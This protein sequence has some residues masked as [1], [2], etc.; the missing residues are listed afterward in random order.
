MELEE[1]I[2]RMMAFSRATYG[3]GRKTE[4]LI[5]HIR[6][7]LEEVVNA[8]TNEERI[9]EWVDLVILSLDG[10]WREIYEHQKQRYAGHHQ[11]VD[12]ENSAWNETPD[13]LVHYLTQKQT[14]NEL[15]DWPDWRTAPEGEPIEHVKGVQ[16]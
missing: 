14:K 3:P 1:H 4:G 15:R 6:S 16:D 7:E 11:F 13:D 5:K 12:G 8:E 2:K 10:L 9:N